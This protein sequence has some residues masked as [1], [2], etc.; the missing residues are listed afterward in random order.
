MRIMC[1]I[2]GTKLSHQKKALEDNFFFWASLLSTLSSRSHEIRDAE[3]FLS[4]KIGLKIKFVEV[5]CFKAAID[6]DS[7]EDYP[8]IRKI[9]GVN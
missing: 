8:L 4:K 1:L 9:L 5:T 2:Y 6:L 3:I 7:E